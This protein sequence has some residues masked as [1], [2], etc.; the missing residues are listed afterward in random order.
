MQYDQEVLEALRG[1]SLDP[2]P[3]PHYLDQLAGIAELVDFPENAVVFREGDEP[4]HV[5]LV[6]SGAVALEYR[7]PGQPAKRI[8]T[9][10]EAELLGW[11]PVL[12]GERMTA[13]ARTL[14]PTRAVRI[15]GAKARALCAQDPRFGC[16]FMRQTAVALAQRLRATRLQLLDV[17][18]HELPA[19]PDDGGA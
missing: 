10:G 11:S 12:G 4:L 3:P 14:R 8:H 1:L 15:D 18:R 7:I 9:V 17:Y 19:A 13:T 16:E 5:Y 6:V 2:P